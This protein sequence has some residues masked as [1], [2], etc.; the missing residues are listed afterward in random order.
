M[1]IA[2]VA[3]VN[4][5]GDGFRIVIDLKEQDLEVFLRRITEIKR[6]SE[7]LDRV[8]GTPRT[9]RDSV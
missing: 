2:F 9:H 3:V 7:Y 8:T 1:S 6:E 4:A 5:I